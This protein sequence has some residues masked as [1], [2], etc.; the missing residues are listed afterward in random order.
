[1]LISDLKQH[2]K[3]TPESR[4]GGFG[5]GSQTDIST[6]WILSLGFWSLRPFG[7]LP[8]TVTL[9]DYTCKASQC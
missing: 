6:V 2:T 4:T 7:V 1:M 9:C 8:K 5:G 3:P